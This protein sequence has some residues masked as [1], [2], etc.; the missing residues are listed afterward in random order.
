MLGV[1]VATVKRFAVELML[2]IPFVIL[3]VVV[4]ASVWDGF[5]RIQAVAT[6]TVVLPMSYLVLLLMVRQR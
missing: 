1:L 2:A 6:A 4:I 5:F 3:F